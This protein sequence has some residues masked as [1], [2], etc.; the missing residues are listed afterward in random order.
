MR[1]PE[2][3]G[4]RNS[5][6]NTKDAYIKRL[7]ASMSRLQKEADDLTEKVL[8]MQK[9]KFKH[10]SNRNARRQLEGQLSLFDNKELLQKDE[11]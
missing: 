1:S 10:S 2:F 3:A 11:S 8:L 4:E 6:M 9:Q 5:I 7:E